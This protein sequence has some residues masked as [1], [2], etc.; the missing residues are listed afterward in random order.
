MAETWAMRL[1]Q[2]PEWQALRLG[3]IQSRG[4]LCQKCGRLVTDETK[5]IGHHIQ[6]LTPENVTDPNIALNPDNIELIC[7]KCHN[8][9]HHRFGHRS[10]VIYIVY[11][12]PCSG[13]TTLVNQMRNRGDVIVDMD[14]LYSAVSGCALYDKPDSIKAVVFR[15]RDVLLDCLRTRTGKWNKAFIIGGY[16]YRLQRDE[17]AMRMG[18]ELIY[19]RSTLEECLARAEERGAFA[20]DWRRYIRRWFDEYEP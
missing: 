16:P 17:L 9:E 2:S 5:L 12:A 11:G 13:K 6:E 3:L 10:Q 20:A 19:C 15:A 7:D 8:E 1:Y 18:A 14:K 4:L